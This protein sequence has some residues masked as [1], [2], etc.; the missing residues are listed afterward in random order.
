MALYVRKAEAAEDPSKD[1]TRLEIQAKETEFEGIIRRGYDEATRTVF[2]EGEIGDGYGSEF[3]QIMWWLERGGNHDPITI[4]L[5]TPG[6][7]VQSMYQ[8][9]DAVVG[10]PCQVTTIGHGEV[11]SAGVLMLV[12]GDRRYVRE[13][14]VLMSH[15]SGGFGA[16]EDGLRY[17]EAKDRRKW[18]DWVTSRWNELMARHTPH[19][20]AYWKSVTS[21]RAELWKLGAAEIIEQG[22]ADGVWDPH[23]NLARFEVKQEPKDGA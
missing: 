20:A 14:C 23:G 13:N 16:G 11:V 19:D 15:E 22:L 3:E 10:S 6:G 21:R 8:F 9:Y 1:L 7:D 12:C 17:S 4:W 5:S 2:V 18:E